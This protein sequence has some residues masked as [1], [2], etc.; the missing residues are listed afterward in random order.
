MVIVTRL[1]KFL[2]IFSFLMV[3]MPSSFVAAMQPTPEQMQQAINEALSSLSPAHRQKYCETMTKFKDLVVGMSVHNFIDKNTEKLLAWIEEQQEPS[4]TPFKEALGNMFACMKVTFFIDKLFKVGVSDEQDLEKKKEDLEKI[5]K[6]YTEVIDSCTKV[7]E[8]SEQDNPLGQLEKELKKIRDD[9]NESSTKPEKLVDV[10]ENIQKVLELLTTIKSGLSERKIERIKEALNAIAGVHYY[11][12]QYCNRL[13]AIGENNSL[14]YGLGSSI[15]IEIQTIKNRLQDFF[16]RELTAQDYKKCSQWLKLFYDSLETRASLDWTDA[17][18]QEQAKLAR[19]LLAQ[20]NAVLKNSKYS[21]EIL[22]TVKNFKVL[23]EAFIDGNQELMITGIIKSFESD[24]QELQSD[25]S[26]MITAFKAVENDDSYKIIIE[27]FEVFKKALDTFSNFYKKLAQKNF[28]A[29]NSFATV[30]SW[31]SE[32]YGYFHELFSDDVKDKAINNTEVSSTISIGIMWALRATN[33]VTGYFAELKLLTQDKL[34][35]VIIDSRLVG[36][37]HDPKENIEFKQFISFI[38]ELTAEHDSM[39]EFNKHGFIGAFNVD[40]S[41]LAAWNI[42]KRPFLGVAEKTPFAGAIKKFGQDKDEFSFFGEIRERAFKMLFSA[43]HYN[44]VRSYFFKTAKPEGWIPTDFHPWRVAAFE[45]INIG[46]TYSQM[47][48]K[49]LIEKVFNSFGKAQEASKWSLGET[50]AGFVDLGISLALDLSLTSP[51]VQSFFK[52]ILVCRNEDVFRGDW[53]SKVKA[54]HPTLKP[55]V[56]RALH[57]EERLVNHACTIAGS[58]VG[59]MVGKYTVIVPLAI[60]Q[61]CLAFVVGSDHELV[62]KDPRESIAELISSMLE[63]DEDSLLAILQF[64][65]QQK[66]FGLSMLSPTD[67]REICEEFNKNKDKA[68]IAKKI[69]QKVPENTFGEVMA[70]VGSQVAPS[71]GVGYWAE[72]VAVTGESIL[73]SS[74]FF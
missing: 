63:Q 16:E 42:L 3:L 74:H 51:A 9:Y 8:L 40:V 35:P 15:S 12:G 34:K 1:N 64:L 18:K 37:L 67:A 30:A 55:E 61:R 6:K 56:A 71:Y 4:L 14:D 60:I 57:V 10:K 48:V 24:V 41:T 69:A 43:F 53:H 68:S 59:K 5:E 25:F 45:A 58:W 72:H 19:V 65:V 7:G 28:L 26:D 23:M 70:F 47:K 39:K 22:V 21:G 32:F 33:M 50:S 13:D 52:K 29:S 44:V 31:I 20:L 17:Q 2:R 66:I 54:K 27:Q 36:D 49:S 38:Q 62:K 73:V 11:V 46:K